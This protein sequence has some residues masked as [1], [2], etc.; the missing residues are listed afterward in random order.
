MTYLE[1]EWS[2]KEL[3][4]LQRTCP[5][6]QKAIKSTDK[7]VPTLKGEYIHA[8]CSSYSGGYLRAPKGESA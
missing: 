5:R 4:Q 8:A 2:E 6:C 1:E 7:V 3:K